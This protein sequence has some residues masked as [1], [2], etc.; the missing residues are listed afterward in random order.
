MG[1]ITLMAS[2]LFLIIFLTTSF[3]LVI[4]CGYRNFKNLEVDIKVTLVSSFVLYIVTFAIW[5][6]RY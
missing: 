1:K 5:I 2:I 6:F 4:N 3:G